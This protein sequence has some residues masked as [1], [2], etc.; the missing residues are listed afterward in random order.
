MLS[1]EVAARG[2][3]ERRPGL[4]SAPGTPKRR[5]VLTSLSLLRAGPRLC[6]F[7]C[8]TSPSSGPR[9]AAARPPAHLA[10]TRSAR[11]PREDPRNAICCASLLDRPPKVGLRGA[12]TQYGVESPSDQGKPS[13]VGEQ[14]RLANPRPATTSYTPR[15]SEARACPL[16]RKAVVLLFGPRG[17]APDPGERP[18]GRQRRRWRCSA[19]R[20]HQPGLP[21]APAPQ[22]RVPAPFRPARPHR[23][24]GCPAARSGPAAMVVPE[25]DRG[26]PHELPGVPDAYCY[27]ARGMRDYS[28]KAG[29]CDNCHPSPSHHQRLPMC[30]CRGATHRARTWAS[31]LARSKR[32]A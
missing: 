12:G 20:M 31:D 11:R 28:C 14:P 27:L 29:R 8:R 13:C 3:A 30:D 17:A 23:A 25:P 7:V 1:N 18:T 9:Q 16:A 26:P 5:R 32:A 24:H 10:P 21:S 22:R 4:A 15:R 6:R 19:Q 2:G